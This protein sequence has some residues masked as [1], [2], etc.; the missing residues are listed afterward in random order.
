MADL[1]ALIR[2]RR[3]T[4]EQKQKFLADLYRQVEAMQRQKAKFEDDLRTERAALDDEATAEALAYFGRYSESVRAKVKELEHEIRKM[5]TRVQ[6]AQEDMRA[7]F[8]EL[9]KIEI[10]HQRREDEERA[11]EKKKED[12]D[13]DD[14][15]IEGYRRGM[16][17]E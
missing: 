5:E 17:E 14:I 10:V 9:K 16:E 1:E 13:L 11:E 15:A 6:I 12:R 4:V 8:A 3:H 2:V 7:A